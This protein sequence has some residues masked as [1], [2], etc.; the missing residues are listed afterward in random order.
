MGRFSSLAPL[1]AVS[2]VALAATYG[3]S[4]MVL[5]AENTSPLNLGL[6]G[7]SMLT[8]LIAREGY[9]VAVARVDELPAMEGHIVY[10][11]I[12]PEKPFTEK[13]IKILEELASEK[14]LSLLIGDELGIA[15][16]VTRSLL[17]VEINGNLARS[18]ELMNTEWRDF[19]PADCWNGVHT[20]FSRASVVEGGEPICI[21]NST[22]W[23]DENVNNRLEE[24]EAVLPEA[25]MASYVEKEGL[26]A[27]VVA[28]SSV[29]A[30]YMLAGYRGV[31]PSTGFVKL[32]VSLLASGERNVVFV[33]D[34]THY[35][36]RK[37]IVSKPLVTLI[38]L[39]RM[40]LQAVWEAAGSTNHGVVFAL[41]TL[42]S[43]VFS[44][45]LFPPPMREARRARDENLLSYLATEIPAL[46]RK[47]M[48]K[49]VERFAD[50]IV[51]SPGNID[52]HL[53]RLITYLEAKLNE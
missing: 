10:I 30:N 16:S 13:E 33:F 20:L 31:E 44:M 7:T 19:V 21:A 45:L 53:E 4:Y 35:S 22:V 26:R 1:L 25:V 17:G 36:Y 51:S 47:T 34:Y 50:K 2:V 29:F 46:A 41:A 32:L 49:R 42:A 38:T 3:L 23:L 18:E 27:V 52:R 48:D 43:A 11:V 14:R 5:E 12:G 6:Y 9:R 24:G 37:N 28:D 8:Q 15:N 40:L 39:P